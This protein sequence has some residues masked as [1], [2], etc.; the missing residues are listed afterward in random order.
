MQGLRLVR[1]AALATRQ[2]FRKSLPTLDEGLDRI[3]R[4]WGGTQNSRNLSWINQV[5]YL[6]NDYEHIVIDIWHVLLLGVDRRS[7]VTRTRGMNMLWWGLIEPNDRVLPD[8]GSCDLVSPSSGIRSFRQVVDG[9]Y[10]WMY[11]LQLCE[12]ESLSAAG[13]WGSVNSNEL[14]RRVPL[15]IPYWH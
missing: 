11:V 10:A 9:G 5:V 13:H 8:V 7:P 1:G 2:M 4:Y 15:A 6:V 3:G 12:L 14:R